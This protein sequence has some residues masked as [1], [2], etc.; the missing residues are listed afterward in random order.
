MNMLKGLVWLD[1]KVVGPCEYFFQKQQRFTGKT[2]YFWLKQI[3]LLLAFVDVVALGFECVY[4]EP[5]DNRI[6]L[7][8][9]VSL[10]Y[11][12]AVVFSCNSREN[13][14]MQRVG[15]GVANPFR[16]QLLWIIYRWLYL[17]ASLYLAV[18]IIKLFMSEQLSL[19]GVLITL[20]TFTSF[21]IVYLFEACDPLPPTKGRA[22]EWLKSL[23]SRQATALSE[24]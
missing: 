19:W 9:G 11:F 14:A 8:G 21:S 20:S 23:F 5:P 12:V 6:V 22:K 17:S 4:C 10:L 15:D 16:H 2:H 1:G 18:R 3:F 7:A 13:A 24:G